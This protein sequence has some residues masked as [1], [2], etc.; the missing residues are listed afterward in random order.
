MSNATWPDVLARLSGGDHLDK[1]SADWAMS[2]IMAGKADPAQLAAFA[3]LLRSKGET[4]EE[5]AAIAGR[6]LSETTR[7]DVSDLGVAVD[8]VG[9]GGDGSNSVNISTMAAIIVA[10]S[11]VPVIKHGN[12]S[13]SS[14]VG[15]ADLLEALG[16]DLEAEA[17]RVEASVREVGI[18]FCF[19][20][21]FHPGMRHAGPVR[22][23]LGIPTVFNLLGP[24]TNPGQPAAGLIG[25]ADPKMAPLMAEVFAGRGASVFV[26]RGD[27]G[28]DEISTSSTTT[29]WVVSAG[30][31]SE[32][33]IDIEEFGLVQAGADALRG[34]DIEFNTAV[35]RDVFAGKSGP[36]RDA[37]LI[38]AAAALASRQGLVDGIDLHDEARRRDLLKRGLE[39]AASA[40][41]RGEA[42]KLVERWTEFTRSQKA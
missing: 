14:S 21:T 36:V 29:E 35:A 40:V 26:V 6:M 3:V 15:S 16:V 13:A 2:E 24:L 18:G 1:A 34:G 10:A 41:D 5:I 37:V 33:S 32:G 25:C 20:K 31:V 9:T 12:R 7:I 28:L 4:P 8:I 38:N 11:G 22:S 42:V 27:D 19:A 30:R 17:V 39:Q 23:A